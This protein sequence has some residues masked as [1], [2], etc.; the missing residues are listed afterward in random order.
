MERRKK[1][2]D[3][4]GDMTMLLVDEKCEDYS[5][6]NA[7]REVTPDELNFDRSYDLIMKFDDNLDFAHGIDTRKQM[8]DK[9]KSWEDHFFRYEVY[10]QPC[11]E[12][13]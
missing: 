7:I 5:L 6:E 4:N 2:Y 3:G 9:L 11:G 8:V 1:M 13:N 12:V 10:V